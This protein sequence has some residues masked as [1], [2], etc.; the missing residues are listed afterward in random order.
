MAAPLPDWALPAA[1]AETLLPLAVGAVLG[2]WV[3]VRALWA[4]SAVA[5]VADVVL[6]RL[7]VWD[8][9]WACAALT[10]GAAW[11][12]MEGKQR[13]LVGAGV[14]VAG[15][16]AEV[17]ARAV[18]P[19]VTL[20]PVWVPPW[21][22]VDEHFPN[23]LGG[24]A[25]DETLACDLAFED[26]SAPLG[27]AV[28]HLGDSLVFGSGVNPDQTFVRALAA[29]D[30]ARQHV[31]RAAPGVGP[32]VLLLAARRALAHGPYEQ[33]VLYLFAGNDL[34]ELG[35]PYVCCPDG[36][37][38]QDDL[39]ARCPARVEPSALEVLLS[40]SPPPLPLRVASEASRVAAHVQVR[41]AGWRGRGVHWFGDVQGGQERGLTLL[42]QIVGRFGAEVTSMGASPVVVVLAERGGDAARHAAFVKAASATGLP[43]VDAAPF[44]A[45]ASDA[46]FVDPI[47]LS[48]AGHRALAVWLRPRLVRR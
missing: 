36:P 34:A 19:A 35:F 16:M 7:A 18:L 32:D 38:L 40:Q 31:V 37:L 14:L 17:L 15:G 28:L 46:D 4:A 26:P 13:L 20:A 27:T 3:G 44:F 21:Q 8:V 10:L 22:V 6:V 11:F 45:Q 29:A 41:W 12:R 48:E 24:N 9:V 2:R 43:V 39:M 23:V 30:P 33:V 5:V 1:L 42:A 25:T 47:H